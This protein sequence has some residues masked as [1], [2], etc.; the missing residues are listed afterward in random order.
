MC[1]PNFL[2][3][4]DDLVHTIK[5]HFSGGK[6]TETVEEET[7][8]SPLPVTMDEE[9]SENVE[10][11]PNPVLL[12][13]EEFLKKSLPDELVSLSVE[14]MFD[15]DTKAEQLHRQIKS[16]TDKTKAINDLTSAI[17]NDVNTCKNGDIDCQAKE[18]R[19]LVAK[20]RK[21][22]IN[23]PVPDKKIKKEDIRGVVEQLNQKWQERRDASQELAQDFQECTRKR[24]VLYQF[25]M[26]ALQKIQ[27]TVSKIIANSSSRAAG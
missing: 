18:I 22:G 14:K 5:D 19:D 10:L 21:Q 16:E 6:K 24:D 8:D 3:P 27:Q 4:L 17:M 12:S 9:S 26:S 7:L 11:S 20:L 1:I 13:T 15:I 23:V 2:K 25:V